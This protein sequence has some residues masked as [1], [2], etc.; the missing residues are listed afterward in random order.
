MQVKPYQSKESQNQNKH[1]NRPWPSTDQ[2]H[3]RIKDPSKNM[4]NF[5]ESQK[6]TAFCTVTFLHG[7]ETKIL[8]Y[9]FVWTHPSNKGRLRRLA[10]ALSR[11][12][13]K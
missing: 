13:G 1:K 4:F 12:F 7:Q 11:R 8:V 3:K 9:L 2:I 5:L 6:K 10:L